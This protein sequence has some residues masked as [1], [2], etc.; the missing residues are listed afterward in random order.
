LNKRL[1][2]IAEIFPGSLKRSR[3][4]P[5]AG[6]DLLLP[7]F[8]ERWRWQQKKVDGAERLI[9]IELRVPLPGLFNR[10]FPAHPGN[11]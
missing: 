10:Q 5:H 7:R 1:P 4:L 9:D 3:D 6:D 8:R 11:C 2:H